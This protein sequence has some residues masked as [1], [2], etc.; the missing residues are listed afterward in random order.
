MQKAFAVQFVSDIHLEFRKERQ[1]AELI[2]GLVPHAPYLVLAGD[3]GNPSQPSYAR[4][5]EAAS[6][7]FAHVFLVAGNHEF[8][9]STIEKTLGDIRSV[10]APMP[11]VHFLHNEV[12]DAEE[13]RIFGGTMWSDVSEH[14]EATVA[15]LI[16]DYDRIR[17]FS[18]SIARNEHH[19]F[20][21]LLDAA[22]GEN[23]GTPSGAKEFEG[24]PS[25]AKEFRPP[26]TS[27]SIRAPPPLIVVS[28]HLPRLSLIHPRYH[29]SP[30]NSAFASDVRLAGDPRISA[31][32][33]G[34]THTPRYGPR[35]FCNP[36]GYPGENRTVTL[37][38]TIEFFAPEP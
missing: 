12:Y 28:H 29:G 37:E 16:S 18:P 19:V 10:V 1:V 15:E 13:F 7:R 8:Y 20:V 38:R 24:T 2:D 5:L 31:W 21:D 25:E 17:A 23:E 34:H 32:I 35:F 36:V 4:F 27:P 26:S 6:K 14:E 3:I 30:L 9:G 11:N 33:Y 22:L